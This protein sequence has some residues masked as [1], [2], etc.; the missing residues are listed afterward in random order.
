[1]ADNHTLLLLR[2]AKAANP[3]PRP[4]AVP[5]LRRPL[6]ERGLRDAVAAGQLLEQDGPIALVVRSPALR[7][8]QTWQQVA[9]ELTNPPSA[10]IDE[11]LY[12]G[13]TAELIGLIAELPEAA[14]R[15]LLIGHNPDLSWLATI[16]S[17]VEVELRTA[18]IVRLE[19]AGPWAAIAPA[20]AA[21]AQFVTPRAP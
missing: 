6:A 12:G 9:G 4:G 11:R 19:L 2:H 20:S 3:D 17:S 13:R 5:D 15:V 16:L 18:S 8:E 10:L 21:L 1:M 14:S 7:V